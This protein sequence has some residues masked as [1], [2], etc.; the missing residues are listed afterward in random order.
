VYVGGGRRSVRSG[1]GSLQLPPRVCWHPA[2]AAASALAVPECGCRCAGG[3]LL[4]AAVR[5][6]LTPHCQ[7]RTCVT[8]LAVAV[9]WRDVGCGAEALAASGW[10]QFSGWPNCCECLEGKGRLPTKGGVD[11]GPVLWDKARPTAGHSLSPEALRPGHVRLWRLG[12]RSSARSGA[13][14]LV[15]VVFAAAKAARTVRAACLCNPMSVWRA[16]LLLVDVLGFL[17]LAVA[18]LLAP[19]D[20]RAQLI[21]GY[22]LAQ[23]LSRW[24][25]ARLARFAGPQRRRYWA[26]VLRL[27]LLAAVLGGGILLDEVPKD[28]R[29]DAEWLLHWVGRHSTEFEEVIGCAVAVRT[30]LLPSARVTPRRC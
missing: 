13:P 27:V 20:L 15:S 2:A 16:L 30:V 11:G 17:G 24:L 19:G 5:R 23:P 25:A 1:A 18:P 6:P 29:A 22:L 21:F 10:P 28:L 26:Y 14:Q 8:G 7:S 4:T 3:L 9:C 12:S